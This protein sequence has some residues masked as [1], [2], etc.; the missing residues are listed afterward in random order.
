MD[1]QQPLMQE[2]SWRRYGLS[3]QRGMAADGRCKD[4]AG[5]QSKLMIP[6]LEAVGLPASRPQRTADDGTVPL[7]TKGVR[8]MTSARRRRRSG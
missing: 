3:R 4:F 7:A 5:F 6:A 1:L 2:C 8:C